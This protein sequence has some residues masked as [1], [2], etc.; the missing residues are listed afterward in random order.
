M[1]KYKNSKYKN[2]LVKS[3]KLNLFMLRADTKVT[4]L[5]D[6]KLL[7]NFIYLF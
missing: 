5:L 4:L 2:R 7:N 3:I 1:Q 6:L